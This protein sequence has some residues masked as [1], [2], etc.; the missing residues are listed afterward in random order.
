MKFVGF[1]RAAISPASSAGVP[2]PK[3]LWGQLS[4]YSSPGFDALVRGD[5]CVLIGAGG[6]HSSQEWR[7]PL[8]LPGHHCPSLPGCPAWTIW[9]WDCE[10]AYP[11]PLASADQCSQARWIGGMGS[12]LRM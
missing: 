9:I 2:S 10:A 6:I 8:R 3:A 11:E 12:T 1:S 5:D 7:V 4:A